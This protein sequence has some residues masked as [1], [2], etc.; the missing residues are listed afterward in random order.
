[1]AAD[2]GFDLA[3]LLESRGITEDDIE[4]QKENAHLNGEDLNGDGFIDIYEEERA[5]ESE[6]ELGFNLSKMK[7]DLIF[8]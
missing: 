7:L 8:L 5:A 1:M 4:F 6:N 3:S 2:Q